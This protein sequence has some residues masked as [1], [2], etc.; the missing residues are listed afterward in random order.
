MEFKDSY[1]TQKPISCR[2]D[3][4]TEWNLKDAWLTANRM[5]VGVDI[6]TEWNLKSQFKDT[7]GYGRRVDIETEWNLKW[8]DGNQDNED[9]VGRYRNRMEFKDLYGR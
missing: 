9:R 8:A 2:V 4:E 5:A 6:E 7:G 1:R 3:I